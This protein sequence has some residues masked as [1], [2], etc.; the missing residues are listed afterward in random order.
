VDWTRTPLSECG[1]MISHPL[2]NAQVVAHLRVPQ[3][4][5][6]GQAA[7]NDQSHELYHVLIQMEVIVD[8]VT[9]R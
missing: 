9:P 1:M 7:E 8:P 6:D 5:P 3:P 2:L 4:V